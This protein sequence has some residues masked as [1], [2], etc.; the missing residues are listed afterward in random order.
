MEHFIATHG[1]AILGFLM[2]LGGGLLAG[3]VNQLYTGTPTSRRQVSFPSSIKSGDPILV[4][5]SPAVTLDSYQ[6]NVGG[7]TCEF[8]GS[9]V[10]T[11][12]GQSGSPLTGH[13]INPGDKL[14]A[15][16]GSFDTATNVRYGF[17]INADATNGIFFGYLDPTGPGILS[18][19]TSTTAN[20]LLPNGM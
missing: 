18:G 1:L 12:V 2:L 7:A 8:G 4:G 6:S 14:Y 19:V 9:F 5:L 15:E 20:V 13:A 3:N 17:T 10:L 11:V 16:G